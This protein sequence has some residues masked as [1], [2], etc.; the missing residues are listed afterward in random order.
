M[1]LSPVHVAAVAVV[2]V[3]VLALLILRAATQAARL[4]SGDPGVHLTAVPADADDTVPV[5]D[6]RGDSAYVT[7]ASAGGWQ[8]PRDA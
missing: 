4:R 1:S 7:V 5:Y 8:S 3:A 6:A 2:V